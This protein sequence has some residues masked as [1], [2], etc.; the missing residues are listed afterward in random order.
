[1][2]SNNGSERMVMT[3]LEAHVASGQWNAFRQLFTEKSSSTPPQM[4]E[5]VLVQ[6]TADP[7]LWQIIALWHSRQ[8][9][10]E[11]RQSTGTPGGVLIFRAVGANPTL[12]ILEVV[13]NARPATTS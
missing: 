11:Y 3:V 4:V 10:E 13:V 5:S 6:S 12:T 8:A 2:S 1:M 7:T 9:L